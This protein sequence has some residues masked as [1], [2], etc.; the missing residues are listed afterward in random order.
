MTE[1]T[2]YLIVNFGGPRTL[3]EIEPFLKELLTDK[4]VVRTGMPRPLH[5]YLFKRI[6]KKRAVKISGEYA[7]MGGGSPIYADTEAVAESIRQATGSS[8]VTFHRYLSATHAAFIETISKVPCD[9]IMVFPLF[10]QFT[11]A[12]SG[13]VARWF[14]EHLP[15]T[16][17]NK[18]RW[19]K[20]YPAHPAFIK[21]HQNCIRE[22]LTA[23]GL[24][25]QEVAL[26]FTAHGIPQSFVITGD[27][28]ESECRLSFKQVMQAFPQAVGRLCYQSK[29]GPGE[30]LRPYTIDLC[31]EIKEW[32]QGR[33]HVLFVPISFTS[34]HIE[35]LCEIEREYMPVVKEQGLNAYRVPALNR[36]EDW[37]QAI[38]EIM[39]ETNL[40]NNQ[41]LVRQ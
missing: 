6:A 7:H 39:R 13:S 33:K 5:N 19:I 4:D 16:T 30:W 22:F 25:E 24:K 20:S 40:C 11:Y 26:V 18:L 8:V 29:F 1:R 37:L 3:P 23:H 38:Q 12:T 14:Q 28:Y 34:D 15:Y 31:K 17:M 27:L 32:H 35:T 10:P 2:C 9:R 21:V 41:M 36:R